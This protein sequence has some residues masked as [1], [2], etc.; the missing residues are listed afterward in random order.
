MS[1]T[2]LI[3]ALVGI[4]CI[5]ISFFMIGKEDSTEADKNDGAATQNHIT[6]E[7]ELNEDEVAI[8]QK[9]VSDKITT[10]VNDIIY[11]ADQELS[12][13]TNEKMMAL[14]DYAVTVCDEI[15]KNHKEVMF[16][17][18]MLNDKEKELKELV[19]NAE[20]KASELRKASEMAMES[21]V[22]V[23]TDLEP[24]D[25]LEAGNAFEEPDSYEEPVFESEN[26][27][28][29]ILEMKRSG[30]SILEIARQLGLGVGE[31]KLVVD[32]YQNRTV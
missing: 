20:G 24:M 6:E 31:V 3:I 28:D 12:S 18:S 23:P 13:M 4:I 2:I 29:I 9:K 10:D 7:Y 1:F 19:T 26:A 30:M 27:N 14:G 5:V 17:Y 15:E 8:L 32:L 22:A 25:E 11:S 16:L 21:Y